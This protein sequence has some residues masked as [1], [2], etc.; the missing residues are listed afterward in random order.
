M[1][2]S[3]LIF[4]AIFLGFGLVAQEQAES[5]TQGKVIYEDVM[6]LEIKLDGAAAQFADQLPKER[7]SKKEL[8]FSPKVT[9]YQKASESENAEDVAMSSGGAVFQM[10][11][12]EPENKLFYDIENGKTVEKKEFMTRVFL[13]EGEVKQGEW[14][15]T[16]D[17]KMILDIP[18]MQAVKENEEGEKTVAWFA[19]S[20]PVSSG[21]SNYLGLPGLVLEVDMKEGD[22]VITAQSIDF[23]ELDKDL[24][25]KPKK[26]KKVTQEEYDQIVKEKMEEMGAE[27]GEGGATMMIR[28]EK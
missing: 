14:K 18:C 21:P 5:L 15:I 13:I 11:M 12:M 8:L 26:G 9:L 20:I 22:H 4:T 16:G 27:H 17:Q 28:I 3:I 25:I 19:P 2:K 6:K 23:A 24:L 1:K 7:K 10:K